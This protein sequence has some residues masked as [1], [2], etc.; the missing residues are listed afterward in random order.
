M[1]SILDG[2]VKAAIKAALVRLGGETRPAAGGKPGDGKHRSDL[3]CCYRAARVKL[4][5]GTPQNGNRQL[6][7]GA[8]I[9]QVLEAAGL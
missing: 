8:T 2:N 9:N 7:G 5:G 4:R 3:E 6:R 1:G